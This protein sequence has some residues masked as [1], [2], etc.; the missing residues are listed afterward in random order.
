MPLNPLKFPAEWDKFRIGS[1][2]SPGVCVVGK[3]K[4]AHEWDEKRG[5]GVQGGTLTYQ[6]IKLAHIP[7]KIMLWRTPGV[8]GPNDPDDFA[9]WEAFIPLLEYDPTKQVLKALDIYYPSLPDIK[10]FNVVCE[11]IGNVTPTAPGSTLYEVEI[12]LIQYAPPP[13]VNVTTTPTG[14]AT[15]AKPPSGEPAPVSADITAEQLLAQLQQAAQ[16]PF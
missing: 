12:D 16:N 4:R 10:V 3:A 11:G 14:A 8:T 7:V 15:N 6:G 13:P 2:R 9:D 5:K 1:V